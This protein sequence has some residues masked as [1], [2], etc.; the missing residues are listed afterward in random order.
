M[1]MVFTLASTLKDSAEMLIYERATA[2]EQE[3]EAGRRREEE[4][5]ME[6]FRGELVN[7][8][9]FLDWRDTFFAEK[10]AAKQKIADDEE[11]EGKRGQ[12]SNTKAEEKKLSGRE[13]W[14]SGL[15]GHG[16]EEEGEDESIDV[17]KLKLVN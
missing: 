16:D 11:A 1:A 14:E 4:K 17:A 8:E 12:R 13:M 6:K 9:R 10:A 2:E 7:R 15:V 3:A 5:E